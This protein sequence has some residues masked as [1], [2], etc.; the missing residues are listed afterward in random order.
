MDTSDDLSPR[1]KRPLVWLE[2]GLWLIG[3]FGVGWFV[4]VQAETRLYQGREEARLE[5]AL[6]AGTGAAAVATAGRA[7]AG[8]TELPGEEGAS[9]QAA[10]GTAAPELPPGAAIGRI[11]VPRLGVSAI[12]ASGIDRRT[13]RRAVGHVP[14]TALPGEPG[15]VALAAHRD[16][17]FRGLQGIEE[18]DEIL[19][20]TPDGVFHYRVQWREVVEPEDVEVLD[21]TDEPTLTLVT[22]FPF[23]YVGP[24]PQRF[25]VR[26]RQVRQERTDTAP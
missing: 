15:N 5:R 2:R 6:A 1:P 19:I 8:L 21:D 7:G 4:A 16:R 17:F 3:L 26:A 18:D 12:V 9:G 14:A 23:Y 13:L 10:A 20:T 11:E 24:A 25:I 22:C